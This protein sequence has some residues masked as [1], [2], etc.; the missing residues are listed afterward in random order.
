MD[1]HS[2]HGPLI[3]LAELASLVERR[4]A[5]ALPGAVVEIREEYSPNAEFSLV[6]DVRADGFDPP[7][8]AA[9][10]SGEP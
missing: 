8:A 3:K 4:L 7:S 5:I 1:N 9:E 10:L 6:L 2:I